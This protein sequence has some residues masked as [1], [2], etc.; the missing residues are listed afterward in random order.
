MNE[1][2]IYWEYDERGGFS[3]TCPVF[4]K[5]EFPN[6]M[7]QCDIINKCTHFTKY[8]VREV[9]IDRQSLDYIRLQISY[10]KKYP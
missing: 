9:K 6:S 1:D 8:E 10:L 3:C 5:Q 7:H 2:C 4:P